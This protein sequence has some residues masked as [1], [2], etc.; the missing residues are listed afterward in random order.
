M[1]SEQYTGTHQK[2]KLDVK[3]KAKQVLELSLAHLMNLYAEYADYGPCL[4][5]I[6]IIKI[7]TVSTS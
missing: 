6:E 1:V 5:T 7:I 3:K 2:K 4:Y